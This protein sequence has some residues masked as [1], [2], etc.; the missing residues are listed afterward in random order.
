MDPDARILP[1]TS[2]AEWGPDL[3]EI[4]WQRL[5]API[6]VAIETALIAAQERQYRGDPDG[7]TALLADVEAALDAAQEAAQGA[8]QVADSLLAQPS[9]QARSEILKHLEAQDRAVLRA[10]AEAYRSTLSP[11]SPLALDAV[12]EARLQPPFVAYAQEVVRLDLSDDGRSAQGVVLVHAETIDG[13]YADNGQRFA[14]TWIRAG[15]EWLMTSWEQIA[16]PERIRA[17]GAP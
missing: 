5:D 7:A 11:A 8:G 1:S 14:A 9:L 12:V 4:F 17:I 10:D 2:P 6:N 15:Q 3:F 13:G 16:T